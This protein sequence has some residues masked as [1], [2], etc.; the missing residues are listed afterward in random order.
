MKL[1]SLFSDVFAWDYSDLKTYDT[2][3]IQ[4]TIPIKPNQKPF[5]QKLRR[6]NPK[7][8][9]SIEKEVNRLYKLGIIVPIQFS[10]WISNLVPVRKKTSE[11][12]LCIDFRNLNKVSLKDNYPLA[13]MD[14]ILQR[15]VGASRMSLLDGYSGYNQILVHE[16]DRDKTAFTTP[17]GTFHYAKMPFDEEH[18]YHLK[19]VFQRCI[20][21]GISLNSKK[22][23]FAMDEGKLLGHIISKDG[24]RIDPARVEAIQQIE[25]LQNKKE[26]QS[27]NGKL[28]FL[29][30][31]IPNLA[32]HLGEITS[33]LKKESQVKWT[34]E[35]VKSF[36][37]VKLALSSAPI[38]ISP[39][40]TQ[41]FILF[42][43][44]SE[45]TLAA[46]LMQKREAYVPNATVKD[47]LVQADPE[48]RRGKWIAALLEYDVEIKPTK[49]IKGQ[50][51]AKLM[52]ETNL[53]VLEINL[54]AAMSDEDE[55][56]PSVQVSEMF[57]SSP[58]Y[59]DILYVLQHFSSPPGMPRNRSRTLKLK[60]AKFCILDSAL[61]WKDPGGMLLN[62]LVEEE[63]KRVVE[64]FHR[65]DCGGHLFWKT[66]TNKILRAGYYWP[67]LFLDV[68]KAIKNCHECQIF[69]GKQKL[70]SLPLKPIEVN[71]PFQQWGLDF[72]GEIHPASSGQ[73]R[74]IL[75]ATD[76]FTKW[77]EA[78][79]TRQATDAV[80][81]SFLET[82]ILSCFGCPSK[83]I[84]DNAAAFKSK[85]MIEFC[86][87]YNISLGHSTA[88]H[89]QGNG[90]AESSNKSLVNIIK[91]LLEISKKGS[92]KKLINALWADRVSQK[93]SIGMSPFELVY[94]TDTV[95][96][97][98]LAVPVV[99]LLQEAGS[100]EDPM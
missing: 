35:A 42:S 72:N 95:F 59:A 88:Y 83:L 68:Y 27:F 44:A 22:S 9:P 58:W 79:P 26:I 10:D 54:I 97:T 46:V 85:R 53:Q 99:K 66:T 63:A 62:C 71:T 75:T 49:L 74:W 93:K 91:K 28:N 34:E 80:I 50:G 5:R 73:H 84:T 15:V 12:R 90:F 36:N 64:D 48:G 7:L 43:F 69:Q 47:I 25:Q 29:R 13:K 52:A 92:H 94:G 51:L 8:L 16:D 23:L 89:P 45:H 67:S 86:Y 60:A 24:I 56:N 14:H 1:L 100:E 20:K 55:E 61:F 18:L 77:I 33:M 3:I 4:H 76:Y 87:K 65:G 82:N 70:Q 11:I 78:I 81:I 17:W 57:L 6:I 32:E 38:L 39:D 2:N 37:L 96:P 40:Y 98:S 19:I 21:Y 41:D 31:F 30:H